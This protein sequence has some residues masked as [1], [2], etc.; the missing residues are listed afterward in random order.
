[1]IKS[2]IL[3]LLELIGGLIVQFIKSFEFVYLKLV[4]LFVTLGII[5]GFGPLGFTVAVIFGSIVLYFILRLAFGSSK[6]FFFLFLI[7]ILLLIFVALSI[8][9]TAIPIE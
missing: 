7:Y 2:P 5:S 4:E 1:M 8:S 6:T 9:A 3:I